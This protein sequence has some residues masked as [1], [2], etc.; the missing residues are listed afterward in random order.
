MFPRPQFPLFELQ[1][2]SDRLQF[3]PGAFNF[4]FNVMH[5]HVSLTPDK[6]ATR[7]STKNKKDPTEGV[8]E[9]ALLALDGFLKSAGQGGGRV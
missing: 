8:V 3:I 6:V 7:Q 2:T 5:L 9:E 1:V 4:E